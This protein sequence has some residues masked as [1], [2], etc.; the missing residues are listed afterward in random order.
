MAAIA[1]L[2][3]SGLGTAGVGKYCENTLDCLKNLCS[4]DQG[5]DW[6]SGLCGCFNDIGI[7]CCVYLCG[8]CTYCH[9]AADAHDI[10]C[11][12]A[13]LGLCVCSFIGCTFCAAVADRRKLRQKYNIKGSTI[14][15][16]LAVACCPICAQCQEAYQTVHKGSHE[17]PCSGA[18]TSAPGGQAMK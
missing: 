17:C 9:T 14:A 16:C 13:C 18:K 2:C 5:G 11:G 8:P 7:C 15:D 4:S 6:E 10:T 3:P 1:Y 12:E